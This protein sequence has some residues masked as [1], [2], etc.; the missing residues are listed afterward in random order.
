MSQDKLCGIDRKDYLDEGLEQIYS[1]RTDI[2]DKLEEMENVI[3]D[4]AHQTGDSLMLTRAQSYWLPTVRGC[5]DEG[6]AASMIPLDDTI[7]EIIE[8]I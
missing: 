7:K 4:I 3:R 6:G 2:L 8:K 1:L 5:L